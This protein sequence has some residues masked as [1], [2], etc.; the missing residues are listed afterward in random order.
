VLQSLYNLSDDKTEFQIRDR[1][2]FMRFLGLS[3]G[4]AVPDAK[5]IWLFREQLTE[6]ELIKPLFETFEKYLE[7]NGYSAKKDRSLMP[8]LWQLPDSATVGRRIGRLRED[9][10]RRTGA[11]RRDDRRYRCPMDEEERSESLRIQ[12]PH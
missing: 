6:A 1:L 10:Y 12:K 4:D 7:E 11:S 3:L 5:T 2:S 8:A 9:R